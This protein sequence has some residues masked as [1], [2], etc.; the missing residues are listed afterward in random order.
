[1][2]E[3]LHSQCGPELKLQYCQNQ[4]IPKKARTERTEREASDQKNIW[5]G[6]LEEVVWEHSLTIAVGLRV[7]EFWMEEQCQQLRF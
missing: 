1:V 2:V 5:E 7:R 4:T 3:H 6:F